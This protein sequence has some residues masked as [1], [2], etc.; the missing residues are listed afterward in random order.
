M[1][2]IV[3][4]Q[5]SPAAQVAR[6]GKPPCMQ[7]AT[8]C[9]SHMG[10]HAG[11]VPWLARPFNQAASARRSAPYTHTLRALRR[12]ACLLLGSLPGHPK[13]EGLRGGSLYLYTGSPLSLCSCSQLASAFPSPLLQPV[14]CSKHVSASKVR[15]S[16]AYLRSV[17][18]IDRDIASPGASVRR[19]GWAQQSSQL[20]IITDVSRGDMPSAD[21]SSVVEPYQCHLGHVLRFILILLYLRWQNNDRDETNA[22]ARA[23]ANG[24][25]K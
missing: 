25:F 13:R 16:A 3:H 2:I 8:G 21:A 14:T 12:L 9:L 7:R 19:E 24:C 6:R 5:L 17:L 15:D 20:H 18:T 1:R 10:S 22:E 11:N 23:C 4:V